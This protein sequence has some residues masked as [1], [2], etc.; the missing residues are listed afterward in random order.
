MDSLG[1]FA[2]AP[3]IA[4][5]AA[6]PAC[7]WRAARGSLGGKLLV[8]AAMAA[9][10]PHLA[11]DATAQAHDPDTVKTAFV[12]N[13]TKY[14]E[15][16]HARDEL[17]I[18]FVGSGPMGQRLQSLSGKLSDSRVLYVELSPS[19]EAQ[20]NCDIVFLGAMPAKT[21]HDLL[22][23][24][25]P[26]GVLTVSDAESF[27]AQGGMI[28]LVT[29]GDHIQLEVNLDAVQAARLKISSRLLNVAVLV[30][31]PARGTLMAMDSS[32]VQP[33]PQDDG[34][35]AL[36]HCHGARHL[37]HR[38]PAAGQP[39]LARPAA[40]PVLHPGRYCGPEL[41]RRTALQRLH[42]RRRGAAGVA[43]RAAN[44]LRLPL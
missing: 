34:S 10:L 23:K 18:G 5:H 31:P 30:H 1:Q 28:G 11:A 26:K 8:L 19:E 6:I 36:R 38:I 13:L 37:D 21:R 9:L 7:W 29:V 42:R 2:A 27:T 17:I 40:Q 41:H 24:L 43:R 20:G 4:R 14:V 44:F 16:R 3:R 32:R 15:W 35:R 25:Q 33:C 12:Y 39:Q 22:Q